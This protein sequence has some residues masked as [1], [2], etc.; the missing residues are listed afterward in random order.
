MDKRK[1]KFG[2]LPP[3]YLAYTSN[4][5]TPVNLL[6]AGKGKGKT[7]FCDELQATIRRNNMSLHTLLITMNSIMNLDISKDITKL[8]VQERS[9]PDESSIKLAIEVSLRVY[10]SACTLKTDKTVS[11]ANFCR[12][13]RKHWVPGGDTSSEIYEAVFTEMQE[14]LGG[15]KPMLLVIDESVKPTQKIHY[16]MDPRTAYS[17]LRDMST[18]NYPSFKLILF[19]T[20]L[21]NIA[22]S[23]SGTKYRWSCLSDTDLPY[24]KIKKKW[25][26]DVIKRFKD[27]D[28]TVQTTNGIPVS[29]EDIIVK[30]L[31]SLFAGLPRG[32]EFL[33]NELM[34]SGTHT[35]TLI[36]LY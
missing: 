19:Q 32:I 11:F 7:R 13:A 24:A 25:F 8:I 31:V 10:Y 34:Q 15:D 30:P 17:S 6:V 27:F 2:E 36:V 23:K 5:D 18:G 35:H 4:R 26:A 21:E 22:E 29:S 3:G 28:S 33:R 1:P 9:L 14:I 12:C 20:S 16:D